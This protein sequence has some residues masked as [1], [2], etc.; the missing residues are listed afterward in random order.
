M[1]SHVEISFQFLYDVE[2][3]L[4]EAFLKDRGYSGFYCDVIAKKKRFFAIKD[5][6]EE[7]LNKVLPRLILQLCRENFERHRGTNALDL[8]VQSGKI[9]GSI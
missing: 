9:R 1:S 2:R 3:E 8:Q 7:D 5:G 6:V 4:V